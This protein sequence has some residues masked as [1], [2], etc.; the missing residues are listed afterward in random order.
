[1]AVVKSITSLQAQS[2]DLINVY[3]F[4]LKSSVLSKS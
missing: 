3:K 4:K 2:N 1:M